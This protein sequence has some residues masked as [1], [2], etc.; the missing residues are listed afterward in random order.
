MVYTSLK[1]LKHHL[2][3][4][5]MVVKESTIATA[6]TKGS[7]EF[8]HTKDC[9]RDE[10]NPFVKALKDIFNTFD[11]YLIDELTEV[12]NVFH[13]ME[14]A[15]EQH[16]LESKIFKIKMNQVL[17]ENERL[18]KQV[19]NKDIVNIVVNSFMNSTS[20]NMHECTILFQIKVLQV[21][22]Y[23]EL[24][25]WKAQSQEKDTIIRKLKEKIKSL[26]GNMNE[27]K[28]KK[29]IEEIETI[30]IELDHMEELKKLKWKV[31]IDNVITTHTI[32]P[33]M[34]KVDVE[35]IALKLLNNR[36]V[37]SNCLRHTQEQAMILRE[38]VKQGKSKNPL[39]NSLDHACKYTK[40]IQKLLILIRQTCPSINKSSDKLVAVTPKNKD[41]RVRF[42]EPVTTFRN[43][44]SKT[45]SSS[46]LVSNNPALSSTRVKPSTSASGSQPS[47]N[48]KKD[49]IQR[50]PSR[51]VIVQ[52]SMFNA[53]SELICVKCNGCMLS[54]N[55]DF[56]VFNVINEV[57]ARS[58]SKS[59]KNTSKRKVCKSTGKV[60]TKTG[61]T[62]RPTGRTVIIVG[63]ACP[64]T[65]I[66]RTAEV[67]LG[68]PTA[69]EMD[70][71]KPVVTLVYSRIPKKSKT[72]V[73]ISKPKI[74]KSISAKNKEPNKS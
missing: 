12:Q 42:N 65:R 29:D 20:V 43:T 55:H 2:A 47:G 38:V 54:E 30:N 16:R 67:S 4:F 22:Q 8:E 39:N 14:Q 32:A 40:R 48:T 26:S 69:L 56:C 18:L 27:D 37:H 19:I 3:G 45:A 11:Q 70:T 51:T 15:V 62:W 66:T 63:N 53:N 41:K 34:L 60:F 5:D 36:T 35:L 73:L 25:E 9:F 28:V 17:N 50:P 72:S 6:I 23:F 52:H 10:I 33:K 59:V 49:K 61:Y 24:N 57:N 46:N 21:D 58:K 68:K 74:I 64:L 31:V 13:Q 1:K 71:P 7:W 44:N